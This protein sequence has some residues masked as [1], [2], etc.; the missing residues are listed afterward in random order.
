MEKNSLRKDIY[1]C[2]SDGWLW[3]EIDERPSD[4]HSLLH[5]YL[6]E[7]VHGSYN[8]AKDFATIGRGGLSLI[9]EIF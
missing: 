6:K 2:T 7:N 1:G 8:G 4:H 9:Q 3:R 5:P